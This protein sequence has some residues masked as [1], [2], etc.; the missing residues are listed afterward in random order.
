VAHGIA[1]ETELLLNT[2]R[3]L[4]ARVESQAQRISALSKALA[5][6]ERKMQEK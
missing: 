5:A 4:I 2:Q 6:V 1:K 3:D